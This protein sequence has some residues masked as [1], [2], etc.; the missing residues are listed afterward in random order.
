[1]YHFWLHSA[2]LIAMMLGVTAAYKS[3]TL[4]R[5]TPIPN[6]Y[7]VH[8]WLGVATLALLVLQ[9]LVAAGA[10]LWPRLPPAQ[11]RQLSPLHMYLGRAVFAAGLATMA[12]RWTLLAAALLLLQCVPSNNAQ[13]C[14]CCLHFVALRLCCRH[15]PAGLAGAAVAASGPGSALPPRAGAIGGDRCSSWSR[16]AE[17]LGGTAGPRTQQ[18]PNPACAP[19]A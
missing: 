17:Q 6:F 16:I 2:A 9:Y 11:R 15:A 13:Q 19:A 12:V 8:S 3:H 5:P 10:F 18:P 7:S 14:A 1:M 4:K